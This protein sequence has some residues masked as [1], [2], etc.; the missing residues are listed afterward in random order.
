M[1]KKSKASILPFIIVIL[2]SIS[3]AFGQNTDEATIGAIGK[4]VILKK[5]GDGYLIQFQNKNANSDDSASEFKIKD[6]ATLDRLYKFLMDGFESMTTGPVQYQLNE[7]ELRLYYIN[8]RLGQDVVE[9]IHE[10][11]DTEETGTLARLKKKDVQKLFGK[12]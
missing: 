9:I 2:I 10:N 12:D 11:K 1:T 4:Q 6:K 5:A 8:K 7:S 3:S